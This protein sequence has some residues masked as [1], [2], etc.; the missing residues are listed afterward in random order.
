MRGFPNNANPKRKRRHDVRAARGRQ[1]DGR[2]ASRARWTQAQEGEIGWR[3]V[4]AKMTP[5]MGVTRAA[6]WRFT[7][8]KVAKTTKPRRFAGASKRPMKSPDEKPGLSI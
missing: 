7:T 3:R 1:I 4:G 5:G 2:D 8:G 6:T